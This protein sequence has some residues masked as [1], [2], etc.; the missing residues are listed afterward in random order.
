MT[1]TAEELRKAEEGYAEANGECDTAAMKAA[2]DAVIPDH[3]K[4]L[5]QRWDRLPELDNHHNAALCPYCKPAVDV[6]Q[7]EALIRSEV[8]AVCGDIHSE[9]VQVLATRLAEI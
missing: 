2:L 8:C 7:I 3:D 9:R 4:Q 6:Q 1:Y 5:L